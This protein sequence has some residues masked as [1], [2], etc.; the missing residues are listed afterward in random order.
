MK[1]FEVAAVVVPANNG[2]LGSLG[3]DVRALQTRALG[4]V[5]EAKSNKCLV[6][7]PELKL[8][9]WLGHAEL[10][11]VLFEA[12][13]GQQE[14]KDLIPK[15]GDYSQPDSAH[16]I[17]WWAHWLCS[18]FSALFLWDV[19]VADKV[20]ALFEDDSDFDVNKA[21]A[22]AELNQ[23]SAVIRLGV[24]ELDL[25]EWTKNKATLGSKLLFARFLP[26]GLQKI[27]VS[28]C[29]AHRQRTP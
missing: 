27:E 25:D 5:L 4:I 7:F 3:Y 8:S 14:F 1:P 18:N 19:A 23:P 29:L 17:V 6:Q 15:Q 11:D 2:T 24:A 10:K 13:Q 28:V 22:K 26:A 12:A 9:V 16:N 20:T 21:A